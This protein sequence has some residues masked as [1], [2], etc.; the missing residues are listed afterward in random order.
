M[1]TGRPDRPPSLGIAKH[2]S[3]GQRDFA[4]MPD[5]W[6]LGL[7]HSVCAGQI[8]AVD[9]KATPQHLVKGL[10]GS[11]ARDDR[12]PSLGETLTRLLLLGS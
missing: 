2:K 9:V 5:W 7:G 1:T 11:R 4:I 6:A 12:P 10:E 3:S 8:I